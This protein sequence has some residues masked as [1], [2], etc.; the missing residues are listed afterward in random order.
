MPIIW[1][2]AGLALAFLLLAGVAEAEHAEWG[3]RG[4][5]ASDWDEP[6]ECVGARFSAA[7][8]ARGSGG[9][10]AG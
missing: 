8:N 5:D 1:R 9:I 6:G 3:F 10:S 4:R 2:R 7:G